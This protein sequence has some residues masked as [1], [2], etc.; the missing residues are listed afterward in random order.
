MT[1]HARS[2]WR[3]SSVHKGVRIDPDHIPLWGIGTDLLSG[4]FET[5]KM[6]ENQCQE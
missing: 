3:A 2:P 4:K 1:S 5:Q 6:G